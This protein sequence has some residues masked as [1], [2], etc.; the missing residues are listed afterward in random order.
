MGLDSVV[1]DIPIDGRASNLF[2]FG[3][4]VELE[5]DR[6]IR[7]L[8][9]PQYSWFV[10]DRCGFIYCFLEVLSYFGWMLGAQLLFDILGC[11]TR[12]Q[13]NL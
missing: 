9:D 10:G 5:F 13:S 2:C 3:S 12:R 4:C 6:V 11:I 1:R 8:V 7:N